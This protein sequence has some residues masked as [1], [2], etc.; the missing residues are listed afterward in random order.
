MPHT[1]CVKSR[2]RFLAHLRRKLST[3]RGSKLPLRRKSC[4]CLPVIARRKSELSRTTQFL[5]AHHLHAA[6]GSDTN[7][8]TYQ[9]VRLCCGLQRASRRAIPLIGSQQSH[10]CF[11]KCRKG[12]R[13]LGAAA[14]CTCTHNAPAPGFVCTSAARSSHGRWGRDVRRSQQ[15]ATRLNSPV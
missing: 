5:H 2:K 15:L 3:I 10:G 12:L 7:T 9:I 4:G 6:A 14:A 1:A 11:T 13:L 8:D